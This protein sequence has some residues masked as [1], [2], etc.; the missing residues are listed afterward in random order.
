[1]DPH[2]L[3]VLLCL[4]LLLLAARAARR[5]LYRACV[6]RSPALRRTSW[7]DLCLLRSDRLSDW[8]VLE[9]AFEISRLE[10][11]AIH[12]APPIAQR[13]EVRCATRVPPVLVDHSQLCLQDLA[14]VER[15]NV[16]WQS[17]SFFN[18]L[19]FHGQLQVDDIRFRASVPGS[20]DAAEGAEAAVRCEFSGDFT[21]AMLWIEFVWPCC[22]S[23]TLMRT[24]SV[25][26]HEM[27][28]VWHDSSWTRFCAQLGSIDMLLFTHAV[29]VSFDPACFVIARHGMLVDPTHSEVTNLYL[30][31][32]KLYLLNAA[33]GIVFLAAMLQQYDVFRGQHYSVLESS[34]DQELIEG[35]SAGNMLKFYRMLIKD[36]AKEML[37]AVICNNLV[38]DDNQAIVNV[39]GTEEKWLVGIKEIL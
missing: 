25:L 1:M 23:W 35:I 3:I 17:F 39:Y 38:G 18:A 14:D 32:I 19:F 34:K 31:R 29:S 2:L 6:P 11:L 8:P 27:V 12:G 22:K 4:G 15:Q 36:V 9:A 37:K 20:L 5:I 21:S 28:H 10:W 7:R 13:P 33:N 24:V 16:M 30:E 26:L